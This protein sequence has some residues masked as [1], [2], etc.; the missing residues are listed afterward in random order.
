[1][2]R[3]ALCKQVES[4][5]KKQFGNVTLA[6]NV[7]KWQA[8]EPVKFGSF[9]EVA[10][11]GSTPGA[12]CLKKCLKVFKVR[13]CVALCTGPANTVPNFSWRMND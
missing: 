10:A 12:P 3:V 2:A 4:L 5:K 13:C 8:L 7:G 1:M 11:P 9:E 6:A